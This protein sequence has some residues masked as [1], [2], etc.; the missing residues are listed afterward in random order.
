MCA[1]HLPLPQSAFLREMIFEI[2]VP[3]TAYM[4]SYQIFFYSYFQ[5]RF[6]K[7]FLSKCTLGL[8]PFLRDPENVLSVK[9]V[10]FLHD[11]AACFKAFQTQELLRNCRIDLFSSSE[12]PDISPNLSVC[13]SIDRI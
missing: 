8:F 2:T 5:I 4:E 10:I 3:S 1:F 11:N 6:L 12:F 7:A 9:E 13:E